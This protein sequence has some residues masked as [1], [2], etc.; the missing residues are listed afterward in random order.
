M[1]QE[2]QPRDDSDH[3]PLSHK[4]LLRQIILDLAIQP[5]ESSHGTIARGEHRLPGAKFIIAEIVTTPSHFEPELRRLLPER[6]LTVSV[7]DSTDKGTVDSITMSDGSDQTVIGE[8]AGRE[9]D[10]LTPDQEE[11]FIKNFYVKHR[12]HDLK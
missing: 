8:L 12:L 6:L 7:Y 11:Q 1:T 2:P 9:I 4:E 3:A 5:V 10:S